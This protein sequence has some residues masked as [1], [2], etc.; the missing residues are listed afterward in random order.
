MFER[1]IQVFPKEVNGEGLE[2]SASISDLIEL[3]LRVPVPKKLAQ[4]WEN[5]GVGYFGE[6]MIYFFGGDSDSA[7]RDSLLAWNT[8]DFWEAVYPP[9]AQGG[10]VFFAENCFGDQ[11]GFRWSDG[12]PIYILFLVDTFESFVI[13]TSDDEFFEVLMTDRYSLVDEDR[14]RAVF[15]KLGPLKTGM[16]YAPLVSPILGGGGSSDNF[17]FETPI[18]HFRT[19]IQTF[20]TKKPAQFEV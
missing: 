7:A 6:R 19:S 10:P 1:F 16:H 12:K 14:Y 20:L 17:C 4:F 2:D 15:D 11:I 18:V 3:E 8:K 9:P 13:A 5:V